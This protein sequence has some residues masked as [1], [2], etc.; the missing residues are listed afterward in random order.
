MADESKRGGD[1]PPIEE[2]LGIDDPAPKARRRQRRANAETQQEASKDADTDTHAE[3]PGEDGRKPAGE[4]RANPPAPVRRKRQQMRKN[5]KNALPALRKEMQPDTPALR[6][7]RVE[8][9][10]RDL[11]KRRRRKGIGMLTRLFFLVLVPTLVVAWFL[12]ERATPLY[13]S[14][15]TFAVQ[16]AEGGVAGGSGGLLGRFLGGKA[17]GNDPIAVQSFIL[18][19]DVLKR[20]N[21]DYD[22]DAHYQ[23]PDFDYFHRLPRDVKSEDAFDFYLRMVNV[24]FDPSE[25]ILEM[26]VKAATAADAQRFSNAIIG[27]AE[28]MVDN[29]SDPIRAA[30]LKD[31]EANLESA[32]ERLKQ[33]HVAQA[34]LREKLDV[35]SIEIEVSKE[36]QIISA[37][38]IELE[39]LNAKLTNL[40]RVTDESDPRVQRL[41]TQVE[42]LEGQIAAR[43]DKITGAQIV[44]DSLADTNVALQSA[45]FEVTAATTLFSSA[46]ETY[47]AA[48]LDI[49]RQHRYL[50]MIVQ[51]SLPD[52]AT[53]PKK[54]QT[55]ALA[56][57][58][59]L[60]GYILLSL[61]FSLIREQASI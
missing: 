8:A 61:T 40:R 32:E 29:L 51:P 36:M 46:I 5:R 1:E 35:F 21:Q 37:L 44:D 48:R 22:F 11:V 13:E 34:D 25:G 31:A 14:V 18:S 16:S 57:L 45:N 24:S 17:G 60:G 58:I 50:A 6:A 23:N 38:E 59:F 47:E 7:E 43:Q 10:R 27:Y 33:A 12:W 3:G 54:I 53:Y 41:S 9:I 20:L 30:T 56:F 55:T 39:G 28:E 2:L 4:G 52:E 26:T 42:T 49:T 19:R 15:S